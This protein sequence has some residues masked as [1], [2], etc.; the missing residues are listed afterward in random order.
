MVLLSGIAWRQHLL[1]MVVSAKLL[2]DTETML[3]VGGGGRL[4]GGELMIKAVMSFWSSCSRPVRQS[5]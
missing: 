5:F 2:A 1:L 4:G 3:Q